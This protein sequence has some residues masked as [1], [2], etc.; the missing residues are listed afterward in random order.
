M[1]EYQENDVA[2]KE[3][4]NISLKGFKVQRSQNKKLWKTYKQCGCTPARRTWDF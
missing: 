1:L 2:A 3:L 4:P